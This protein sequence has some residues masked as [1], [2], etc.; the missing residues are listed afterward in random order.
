VKPATHKKIVI[1]GLGCG[2]LIV[3]LGVV[4]LI[5]ASRLGMER[6]ASGLAPGVPVNRL[7][8]A[9]AVESLRAV[10]WRA[11]VGRH[12]PDTLALRPRGRRDGARLAWAVW[13]DTVGL[14]PQS[15]FGDTFPRGSFA[16]RMWLQTARSPVV[17]SLLLA[18][19]LP[20]DPA[21][22]PP[23]D[24]LNAHRGG[25]AE[26]RVLYGT[27]A[28]LAAEREARDAHYW[29]RADTLARAVITIGR[30]LQ[31]DS[32]L[33][34]TVVGLRVE[35]EG[36]FVLGRSRARVDSELGAGERLVRLFQAAGADAVH[37]DTLASWVRNPDAPLPARFECVIAVGYGWLHNPN[38][39]LYGLDPRR[40]AALRS[41]ERTSL[42]PALVA[43]VRAGAAALRLPLAARVALSSAP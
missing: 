6:P 34:R 21:A 32:L 9:A 37:S 20:W 38:E 1:A 36:L 43:A 41:L 29:T 2:G 15:A 16:R 31:E 27:R 4:G 25:I 30:R 11:L 23:V 14:V 40:A 8:S 19:T 18:A 26:S 12:P 5:L 17:D 13:R 39:M 10:D 42:P 24:S 3:A 35:R 33:S 7:Q 28:L 22:A